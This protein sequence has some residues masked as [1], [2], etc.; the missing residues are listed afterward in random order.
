MHIFTRNKNTHS[1]FLWIMFCDA[2]LLC[3]PSC[4]FLL[5]CSCGLLG[6]FGESHFH[7]L[8]LIF[9]LSQG[10]DGL[11][12][13]GCWNK[14]S[15]DL[16]RCVVVLWCVAVIMGCYCCPQNG[17]NM[18]NKMSS[19]NTPNCSP[20]VSLCSDPNLGMACVIVHRIFIFLHTYL[21]CNTGEKQFW[22]CFKKKRRRNEMA[23]VQNVYFLKTYEY[24]LCIV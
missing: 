22:K 15:R 12:V 24:V 3:L 9:L 2:A 23:F 7:Y 17:T 16:H 13:P 19:T 10:D 4:C 21:L 8:L 1:S 20:C 14:V 6:S 5:A 18:L 11:P